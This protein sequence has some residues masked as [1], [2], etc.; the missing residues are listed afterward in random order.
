MHILYAD[1]AE[2]NYVRYLNDVVYDTTKGVPL[3]LQ[4]LYPKVPAELAESRAAEREGRPARELSD[5]EKK[6]SSRSMPCIV[7]VQGSAWGKQD[8]Y[9]TL[10][11][12]IDIARLG[13]VVASVE[14]RPVT[15][16][17]F[18]GFVADVKAAIRFLKANADLYGIDPDRIAVWG[19][20]S[21]GHTSLMVGSTGW[22]NEFDDERYPDQDSS[23][24][25]CAA[26]YGVAEFSPFLAGGRFARPFLFDHILG[27]EGAKNLDNVAKMSP[28]TYITP[29]KDYPPFLLIHGDMDPVVPFEQSEFMYQKLTECGKQVDFYQVRGA[30]HGTGF[31]T[32]EVLDITGQF[33][34]AYV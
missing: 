31:W 28:V 16:E 11:M 21:G 33:F 5:A 10:P 19:C 2:Q 20:S 18:P 1:K 7:Y 12:L 32:K 30:G 22:T 14:Y 29:D 24:K 23:V 27:K 25:A 9:G 8:V 26:Y 6:R 34:R 13:F 17:P 3:H 4:M 15:V